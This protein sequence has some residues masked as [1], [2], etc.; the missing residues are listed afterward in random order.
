MIVANSSAPECANR[1]GSVCRKLFDKP[2]TCGFVSDLQSRAP[3]FAQSGVG[4]SA[5]SWAPPYADKGERGR[6][7][8]AKPL[9]HPAVGTPQT[10]AP[11]FAQSGVGQFAK[12]V[13]TSLLPAGLSKHCKQGHP[14]LHIMGYRSLQ[15]VAEATLRRT[16][17]IPPA[18]RPTASQTDTTSKPQTIWPSIRNDVDDFYFLSQSCS[19]DHTVGARSHAHVPSLAL[20]W[21]SRERSANSPAL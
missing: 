9:A 2:P 6:R 8:S 16:R 13:R 17:A 4:Q 20:G 18:G 21:A 12:S 1:G 15:A 19:P 3:L 11:L 14:R 5:H 7:A 10:R